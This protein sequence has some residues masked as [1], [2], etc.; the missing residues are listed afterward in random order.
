MTLSLY[1]ECRNIANNTLEMDWVPDPT[2][3]A[4]DLEIAQ[5]VVVPNLENRSH[6]KSLVDKLI[7]SLM[8]STILNMAV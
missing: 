3:H 5:Q 1:V 7:N 2:E 4:P 6:F 8:Y